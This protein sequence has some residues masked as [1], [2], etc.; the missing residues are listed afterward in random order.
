MAL[1]GGLA[2]ECKSF[3]VRYGQLHHPGRNLHRSRGRCPCRGA[4]CALVRQP[5]PSLSGRGSLH[6]PLGTVLSLRYKRAC[7]KLFQDRPTQRLWLRSFSGK[8]TAESFFA[9]LSLC[10]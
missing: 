8:M 9:A 10:Q 3:E 2:K 1:E 4:R 5:L 6:D 7:E